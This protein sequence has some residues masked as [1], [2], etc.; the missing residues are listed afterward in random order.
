MEGAPN[1]KFSTSNGGLNNPNNDIHSQCILE[2]NL[3][4]IQLE[5]NLIYKK[6]T[7]FIRKNKYE[8]MILLSFVEALIKKVVNCGD[9]I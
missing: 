8:L 2:L 3:T 4:W 1:A 7:Q 9:Y 5:I 6:A